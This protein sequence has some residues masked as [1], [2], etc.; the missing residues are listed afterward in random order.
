MLLVLGRG[1]FSG[2]SHLHLH[3]AWQKKLLLLRVVAVRA[4]LALGRG[5]CTSVSCRSCNNIVLLLL[6][7]GGLLRRHARAVNLRCVRGHRLVVTNARYRR[8]LRFLM[9]VLVKLVDV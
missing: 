7:G 3:S 1:G 8:T 4:H 6:H 2:R 9:I 5:T